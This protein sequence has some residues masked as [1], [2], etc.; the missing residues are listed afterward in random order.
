[1]RPKCRAD[2]IALSRPF[3]QA[4]VGAKKERPSI[5][6]APSCGTRDSDKETRRSE[7]GPVIQYGIDFPGSKRHPKDVNARP[8]R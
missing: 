2:V 3:V 6:Q 4:I 8:V 7:P 1:M 5:E